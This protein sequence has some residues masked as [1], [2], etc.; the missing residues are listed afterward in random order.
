M[1]CTW[2]RK[3]SPT[4]SSRGGSFGN[5]PQSLS[6]LLSTLV[7]SAVFAVIVVGLFLLLRTRQK[8]LY[9]PRTYHDG[10]LET[11]KTRSVGS[12]CVGRFKT[13]LKTRDEFVLN[14][15][16]MDAYLYIRFLKMLTLMAAV[17]AVITW[18]ILLPVNATGGSGGK[19]LNML[20]FSNVGSPARHFAHAIM[21][22]V[23]FGWV[24]FVIGREMMYLAKLRKAYLL[25]TSNASRISQRTVLFTDLPMEDLS[26]EKLHGKFQKVAQIWLVP[27]VGDLEYDVKKLEKAITKLEANEIKYLEAANKHMQKKKTTEYKALRPAHRLNSLIGHYRGQIKTLL[28]KIDAAQRSHLTGKEKLL[29]AVFVEFETISAAEAAF[30]ENRNRRPAKFESRQMGVLP[31][32]IIWKNLGIGSKDRHRRHILANIVIAVLIILW[33]I[34][35]VMIGIISN[36]NYLETGQLQMIFGTSHP[37]AIAVLTGLLPAILLAMLMALVPVVCRF[38]AKLFGAVTRSEV[39][40]QTQSWCFAFQVIQVFLVMTLTASVGP[41][42]LQYCYT[43]A[44]ISTLLL[45]N[46]PKSSNFYMSF[47]ILYGLVI[48]PRYLINTAGLL[49]VVFLS[50]FA[51]TPR[52]KYLRY[53]SLNEPPWGSGYPKWTNLGVIALSYAVVAPLI[54]GFATIGLGLI[55]LVY[56]YKMLYVYDAHVE[57]KGG[58]Y[59]RALEQLMV[60]AYLGELWLLVLF[61]LSLGTRVVHIGP[62]ILQT[63][64]IVATIIFHMYMWRRLKTMTLLSDEQPSSDT[65]APSQDKD[66]PSYPNSDIT[67]TNARDT[68][69]LKHRFSRPH[70][71]IVSSFNKSTI[72][73]PAGTSA[74]GLSPPSNTPPPNRSFLTRIFSRHTPTASQMSASLISD[75]RNPVPQYSEQDV[76]E[77]FLHP[78]LVQREDVVWLPKDK[79]GFSTAQVK[80]LEEELGGLGVKVTDSGAELSEKG[81]VVWDEGSVR[82]SPLWMGRVRY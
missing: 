52:K 74:I 3:W 18:P 35:V 45:R 46:P 33:S 71:A 53:I 40:Q 75:F 5:L 59:A 7:P 56:K 44:G 36:A 27:D 6:A 24:M 66:L 48:A 34:P 72:D 43:Y 22:W 69:R 11:E 10:L 19:G 70:P 23:F 55:Y 37:L 67:A 49:S 21:A 64:L 12:S 16:S 39:E 20:D 15:H 17:G 57:S 51:K 41:V 1:L 30:N 38:V 65:E 47:F 4:T 58:F 31:E 61:G 60:G 8:R 63:I 14:H 73:N 82:E 42:V 50:K 77:S 78:A 25:S 28:P 13:F 9:A 26:L 68:R 76:T 62:I 54:L 79:A 32:E 80:E 81:R 29:S 2:L